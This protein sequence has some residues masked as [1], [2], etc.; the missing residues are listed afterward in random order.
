MK[1]NKTQ[2]YSVRSRWMHW[3]I[4]LLILIVIVL[5]FDKHA[6]AP[7]FG[8]KN[9]VMMWHKSFGVLILAL[10]FIR[11]LFIL[12][13]GRP[14]LLSPEE[15][16]TNILAKSVQGLIYVLLFLIPITGYL[17]C[18]TPISIFDWFSLPNAPFSRN[19]H[20][21]FSHFHA[22]IG[23]VI[24][25]LVALHAVGAI[26]HYLFKKDN[27]IYAMLPKRCDHRSKNDKN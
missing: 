26:Y 14:N 17:A 5:A 10:A 11:V 1:E 19:V 16:L 23:N 22:F 13:D 4:A 9:V 12:R 18:K 2:Y 21:F 20:S 6:F 7:L 27:V 25:Y 24:I 3:I 8:G 15:R